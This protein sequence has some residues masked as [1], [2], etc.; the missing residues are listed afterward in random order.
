MDWNDYRYFLTVARCRT[1]KLASKDLKV[2]QATVGRRITAFQEKLGTQV[3]EKR[4]NGFFL[5]EA[6][7]RIMND[8]EIIEQAIFSINRSILGQDLKSE[9]IVKIAMPGAFANQW[10]IETLEPLLKNNPKLE[11]QFLTGPEV[12][13]ISKR[14]AD[15]AIR[16]VKPNQMDLKTKKIGTLKLGLFVS[17]EFDQNK[18]RNFSH[19][20]FIGL[21]DTATSDLERK[22]LL[23][24]DFKPHYCM[25]SAAWSSVYTGIKSRLGIGILPTF[26]ADRDKQ[27]KMIKKSEFDTPLWLVFHPETAKSTRVKILIDH[28]SK[29]MSAKVHS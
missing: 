6:G 4:S 14:E 18:L 25:R 23:S 27:L 20:P 28:F 26:M 3:L 2:D 13:N 8:V 22:F 7:N 11:V 17:R 10:L 16:L 24:L 21:F 12:L 9:G 19:T 5:T 15:L 29:V 1:L